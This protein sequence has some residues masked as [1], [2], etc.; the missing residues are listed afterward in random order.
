[1]KKVASARARWRRLASPWSAPRL[2][3]S[4]R[5]SVARSKAARLRRPLR[6]RL[7]FCSHLDIFMNVWF[8]LLFY[9][10]HACVFLY[11]TFI[12]D[13]GDI[14]AGNFSERRVDWLIKNNLKFL[15]GIILWDV[16]DRDDQVQNFISR[17]D[18]G[19]KRK[20]NIELIFFKIKDRINFEVIFSRPIGVTKTFVYTITWRSIARPYEYVSSDYRQEVKHEK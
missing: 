13:D 5:D 7:K 4:S 17:L 20:R 2:R 16:S 8:L 14:A 10:Y 3:S 15:F 12:V 6:Q 1:M 18:Q 11:L 19:C 9:G